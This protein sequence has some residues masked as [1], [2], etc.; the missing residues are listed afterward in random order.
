MFVA[1]NSEKEK[2]AAD[3]I[4]LIWRPLDG[5]LVTAIRRMLERQIYQAL[6]FSHLQL[7]SPIII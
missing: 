3:P 7:S 4:A 1:Q 2:A 6:E 5:A